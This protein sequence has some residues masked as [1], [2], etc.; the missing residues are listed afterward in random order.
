K[1][2]LRNW[3]PWIIVGVILGAILAG[4]ASSRALTLVFASVSLVVAG[5]MVWGTLR[6]RYI[7]SSLPTGLPRK[8]I[9]MAVGT[10]SSLMGIGGGTLTVPILSLCRYPIRKAIGT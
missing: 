1:I 7:A 10:L 2:L 9:G 4:Y 5:Y 8:L 3:A 6:E